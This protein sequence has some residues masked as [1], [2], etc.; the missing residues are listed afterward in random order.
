MKILQN[1]KILYGYDNNNTSQPSTEK[2]TKK[3]YKKG[4]SKSLKVKSGTSEKL[5]GAETKE[6]PSK[7]VVV[8]TSLDKN[9]YKKISTKKEELNENY[10]YDDETEDVDDNIQN[11]T[12]QEPKRRGRPKKIQ[13]VEEDAIP[14]KK[15][16]GRPKKNE[17]ADEQEDIFSQLYDDSNAED[18]IEENEEENKNEFD[19]SKEVTLPGMED[20]WKNNTVNTDDSDDD[21]DDDD[22]DDDDVLPGLNDFN[23][24]VTENI[25][26]FNEKKKS[27][28]E[29]HTNLNKNT[30]MKSYDNVFDD[31]EFESLLSQNKKVV[32]FV[33]TSKNG[34]SF[35]IN[36]LAIIL[37]EMG[38]DTAILDTTVNKNAYYIYT[39]NDEDLRK[40]ASNSFEKLKNGEAEGIKVN[41][42]LTVYTTI[43]SKNEQIK[44]SRPIL[45]G[46]IK[47]HS[48]VLID[49][50]FSTPIEYFSKAQEIYLVQSMD[51]LTIQPLTEF[52]RELKVK[53]VL[54][55]RKIRIVIN[56]I[57]RI[58]GLGSKNIVGG[59]SN[60]NDPEMSFMTELFDRTNAKISAQIPFDEDVYIKYL[61]SLIEC[62][63]K[64]NVYPKEFRQKLNDLAQVV[65][66]LLPGQK[67]NRKDKKES[68]KG[69]TSSF[70]PSMNSTLDSM[71]KKY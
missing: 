20:N 16:R 60:Y 67:N 46:L 54:D 49:C 64:V 68:K 42:N 48:L 37:S 38:V 8:P 25:S 23:D 33:G 11:I 29:F 1:T 40:I 5:I 45:E 21:E 14:A 28:I 61:E 10:D 36:N 15:K 26:D 55:E 70:S 43:P 39:K 13:P 30:Y 59:M 18:D 19:F 6:K 22:E 27:E 52:L 9:M 4:I 35:M 32:S 69:Y 3:S 53:N 66:P 24:D 17:V 2:K 51:V 57:L 44:D 34:T 31:E 47:N 12:V 50:D 62:E 7:P 63:I 58:K 41:N 56:K 71:R 65:Y